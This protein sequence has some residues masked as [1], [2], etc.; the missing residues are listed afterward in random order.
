MKKFEEIMKRT[1]NGSKK[2]DN[3]YIKKRFGKTPEK[4]YPLFIAD[5]DYKLPKSVNS[6]VRKAFLEAD[7][8]YFD[9]SHNYYE[10]II[11][12]YQR[13]HK[14]EV[15]KDW[16]LPSVGTVSAMHFVAA[17]CAEQTNFLIFTPVYGVFSH[18]AKTFGSLHTM[19]LEIKGNRYFID[20][21]QLEME[22]KKKNIFNYLKRVKILG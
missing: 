3:E 13:R 18:I 1:D 20:F 7:F 8:G 15:R 10:S 6:K 21:N 16:I 22:I 14:I 9:L 2:W 19:P 17:A 11:D 12:W 4:I 5:M